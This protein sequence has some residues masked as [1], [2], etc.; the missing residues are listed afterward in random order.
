VTK[1]CSTNN[2]GPTEFSSCTPIAAT[3][4]NSWTT[5]S[6]AYLGGHK[7]QRGVRTDTT[8]KILSGGATGYEMSSSTTTTPATFADVDGVCYP[9]AST[10]GAPALG[11]PPADARSTTVEAPLPGYCSQWP[12]VVDTALTGGSSNS[13]ADVAQYYYV[14]DLRPSMENNVR[15]K[16]N[17]AEEDRAT[18]QHMTTFTLALG[19]SGSLKYSSTYKVDAVGDF[20]RIRCKPDGSGVC[21]NT[22]P[23]TDVTYPNCTPKSWP[24][25]PD[26]SQY[27]YAGDSALY[28]NPRSIDDFWHAAVNGRGLYFS[29]DKPDSVVDGLQK[30]LAGIQALVGS[31]SAAATS[32]LEPVA[33]DNY[34]YRASYTTQD[35]VGDLAAFEINLATGALADTSLWR[36]QEQLDVKVGAGCD[37]RRIFLFRSGA[38]NN[39]THFTW[40]SKACDLSNQPTGTADTGLNA[41]EQV[42]FGA[43][44]IAQLSQYPSMSDGSGST[45]NQ[46]TAAAGANL[47]NYLRGQHTLEG[48][49]VFKSNDLTTLYRARTH[50]LG[51]LVNSQP[52][53][54][55]A[56]FASYADSGYATF[57]SDNASRTSMVYAGANDGMLHAFNAS[58]GDEAWAVIPS[59]VLPNLFKLADNNYANVHQF[60]VDGSPQVG[61]IYV[62]STTSWKTIL[63]AGLNKGGKGYYALDVT[64][65]A[66]PK[67]LWEFSWSNSCWDGTSSGVGAD[68]HLGYSYGRPIISKLEDGTWVVIVTSGLNNVNVPAKSGDGVGYLYVLN[69][70]T[71]KLIYKIPTFV[72]DATTPSGLNQINNFVDNI[73]VNNTTLR[74]YGVDMLGNAWRFDVNNNLAPAGREAILLG[75][76]KDSS[77]M[78]QPISTRPE[79]A[80]LD[81]KPWVFFGTGRLVGLAD[82]PDV[83]TQTMYGIKDLLTGFA[84]G[85]V[86]GSA[87]DATALP[88]I[89]ATVPTPLLDLRV[90]L[91]RMVMTQ[92]GSGLNA[93]R[94]VACVGS[95]CPSTTT[96]T[97]ESGWFVDLPDSGERVNIDP[98]LQLGTLTFASNVPSNSAC[99]IGGYSWLNFMDFRTGLAVVT[100][101]NHAAS[102][103]LNESLAVGTNV[104]RLPTGQVVV[105]VIGSNNTPQVLSLPV[106]TPPPS[107]KRVSWREVVVE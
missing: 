64:D 104:L 27:D 57:K 3:S 34:A 13:L 50:V 99:S 23:V 63:V 55:K 91:Q 81:G 37:K 51:D 98:K 19:V 89:P 35:W 92:T 86:P 74:V 8:T 66:N 52:A 56:P 4:G 39:L 72:G 12:C 85:G 80:E 73:L 83:Q 78:P 65:P 1:T 14:T 97:P 87:G 36:A 90:D 7:L 30:A 10:L 82:L 9:D 75:T 33:G 48:P 38:T 101:A 43:S 79:L 42:H 20:A 26:P 44:N 94:T 40:N 61:D 102:R 22:C 6:C 59:V 5:T 100:S 77:N 45:V 58:T 76:A 88:P 49:S 70:A 67:G 47:V 69:A 95:N 60:Y 24:V 17:G 41:A 15:V 31:A 53:F 107:G 46:R 103:R 84:S 16:G 29:A 32:N 28:S 68:C 105:V 11:Y 54:V 21:L 18:H 2:T 71:G 93:Y 96:D 106:S 62:T 25:W